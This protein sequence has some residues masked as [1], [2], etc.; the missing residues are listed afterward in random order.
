MRYAILCDIH[1]NLEALE[2]VLAEVARQGVDRIVHLGD[3][4]GYNANPNECVEM[5]MSENITSILGNHDAAA[6]GLENPQ[7][8]NSAAKQ[9]I[10]WT[11]DKLKP[12]NKKYL[13]GLPETLVLNGTVMLSHGSP[14]TRDN[15]ILDQMDAMRQ[16]G[17]MEQMGVNICFHGHSHFPSLF[18]F[19]GP[20]HDI[21]NH[22]KHIL[23]KTNRYLV[24]FGALGQPRDGDPRTCFG[25]FDTDEMSV[26]FF[27]LKYDVLKAAGKIEGAGLDTYLIERLAAGV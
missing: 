4:V 23:D 25:I 19:R 24:N 7:M 18:V 8:F 9:A 27:R 26:E 21:G 5:L 10:L 16:F 3:C 22:G 20:E 14:E 17:V 13:G 15:Y 11:R 12:K 6:C 1:S 2:E